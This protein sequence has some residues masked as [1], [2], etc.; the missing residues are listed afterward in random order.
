MDIKFNIKGLNVI[1]GQ[2]KVED[3]DVGI[4]CGE[5][6]VLNSSECF[7]ELLDNPTVQKLINKF[8]DEVSFKP[9]S[10]SHEPAQQ[11]TFKPQPKQDAAM[12]ELCGKVR[13]I[14]NEFRKELDAEK[15]ARETEHKINEMII[16]ERTRK[17]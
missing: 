15:K 1:R 13:S 4:S 5:G 7:I 14:L 10:V 16:A 2:I 9:V 17:F 3:L 8:T 6:E 11:K 12:E